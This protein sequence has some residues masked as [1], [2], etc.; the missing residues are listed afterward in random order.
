M[1]SKGDK[2]L[3]IEDDDIANNVL[4]KGLDPSKPLFCDSET[5]G[6]GGEI[7]LLQIL[8]DDYCFIFDFAYLNED[9]KRHL[10]K[11]HTIWAN[12]SYDLGILDLVTEVIDDVQLLARNAYPNLSK[13]GVKDLIKLVDKDFYKGIDTAEVVKGFKRRDKKGNIIELTKDHLRYACLDTWALKALWE[14]PEVQEQRDKVYYIVDMLALKYT[15]QFQSKGAIVDTVNLLEEINKLPARIQKEEE[16]LYGVN[17]NS[18]KQVKEAFVS[19]L[20]FTPTTTGKS[21]LLEVINGDNIEA[22]KFAKAVFD[23]R[24]TKK[25][26]IT[27]VSMEHYKV[28][29]RF[30]PYGT[31]TGRYSSSGKGLP[32]GINFQNIPRDLQYLTEHETEDTIVIHAD[33]STAELR[34]ACSLMGD[35]QMRRYLIEGID[36]HKVSAIL[37]NPSLTLDTVTKEDRQKGKAVSF[38]FAFG[39]GAELFQQYALD[40]YGVNFTLEEAKAVRNNYQQHYKNIS[41]YHKY[42]WNAYKTEYVVS[43]LGRRVKP[44]TGTDAIN[45][46]TQSSI[47]ETCK[48]AIHYLCR[49]NPDNI[50]YLY[51]Q[52]HDALLLRVPKSKK[53]EVT[54]QLG[55]AMLKAWDEILKKPLFKFKDIPMEI[56]IE[57]GKDV[58]KADNLQDIKDYQWK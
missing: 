31:V 27:L 17:S 20:G 53:K 52:V 28:H 12:A 36:L 7:R 10:T 51:S 2:Y 40:T 41:L 45:Y 9:I 47:G 22:S 55:E 1:S 6:I 25:R 14:L 38:G 8:Q 56:E 23:N 32:N 15:I 34:S 46:S 16:E 3:L 54:L 43:P 37:A 33:Y 58:I 50:K 11:Y 39:M 44:R 35:E 48:L 18:P 24:R 13:F 30:N 4:T 19:L 42:W 5:D 26:L 57:I 49:D 29:T 21:F